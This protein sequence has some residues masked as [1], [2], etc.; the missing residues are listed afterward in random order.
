MVACVAE[1]TARPGA[2]MFQSS[3]AP[4][5]FVACG[6][7]IAFLHHFPALRT[8]LLSQSSLPDESSA[9]TPKPLC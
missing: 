7:D 9:H 5:A 4:K 6:T 8:G 1:V 3:L 2:R